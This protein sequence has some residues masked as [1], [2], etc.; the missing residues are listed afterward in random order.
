[1]NIGSKGRYYI[2]EQIL[3]VVIEYAIIVIYV[4]A[5]FIILYGTA[6]SVYALFTKTEK[7]PGVYIG[8]SLDLGLRYLMV[9]EVLHTFT[10]STLM[11]LVNLGVLLLIRIVMVIF[12]QKELQHEIALEEEELEE[13]SIVT[14]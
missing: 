12:N 6:M 1:M 11:S 9:S 2:M 5:L 13:S 8:E 10:A 14:E 4:I 7:S 3:H